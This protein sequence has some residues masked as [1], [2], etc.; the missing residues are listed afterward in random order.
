MSVVSFVYAPASSA[1]FPFSLLLEVL[2]PFSKQFFLN[3]LSLTVPVY[4][5]VLVFSSSQLSINMVVHLFH[6][7]F[8]PSTELSS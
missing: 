3:K 4:I 1:R 8:L 5:F 2:T 6:S 7:H